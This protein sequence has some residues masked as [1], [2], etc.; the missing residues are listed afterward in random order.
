WAVLGAAEAQKYFF[1][2]HSEVQLTRARK[3]AENA[4]RLAPDSA[5]AHS[6]MGQ[7]YYYCLQDYDRALIDLNIAHE[8]APNDANILLAIGLVQRRQGNLDESITTQH[9][10]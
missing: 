1:P 10:A 9:E 6:A 3:A 4:V 5:E 2:D 8:R 7:F